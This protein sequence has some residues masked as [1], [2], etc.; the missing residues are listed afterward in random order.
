MLTWEIFEMMSRSRLPRPSLCLVALLFGCGRPEVITE[1]PAEQQNLRSIVMAYQQAVADRSRAP[2]N[3]DDLKPYVAEYGDAD[4]ILTSPTD[5]QPYVIVWNIE[6]SRIR[7]GQMPIVAYE[8]TGSDGQHKAIDYQLS[9]RT[10]NGQQ[11]AAL[12]RPRQ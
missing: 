9:I 12:P 1:L 3:L 10:L 2:R 11:V 6:M 5:G 8:R 4:T 7:R